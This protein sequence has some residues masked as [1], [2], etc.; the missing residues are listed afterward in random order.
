MD[1]AAHLLLARGT[2][3]WFRGTAF[4]PIAD[5]Y[6]RNLVHRGYASETTKTYTCGARQNQ[7]GFTRLK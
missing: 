7:P 4:E 5:A 2:K 1:K 6:V 3:H